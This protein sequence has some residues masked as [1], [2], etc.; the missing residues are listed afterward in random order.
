M[1]APQFLP[2][3]RRT[4]ARETIQRYAAAVGDFN[5]IHVD[6]GFARTSPF[7]GIIAHGMWVLAGIAEMLTRSF[8]RDWLEHGTLHARFRA[9][10]R[11]GDEVV[12]SGE[13]RSQREQDGGWLLEYTVRCV[14][15]NGDELIS[16]TAGVWLT[17]GLPRDM[18][19]GTEQ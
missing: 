2:A 4:I 1:K 18:A 10:A 16:G 14:N 11:L 5:P 13:L 19:R 12:T 15:Q 6:E 7:G 9:P 8:G 17:A 3:V